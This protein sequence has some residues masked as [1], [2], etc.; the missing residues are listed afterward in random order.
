[1]PINPP[2]VPTD[3]VSVVG[4]S[5]QKATEFCEA[6]NLVNLLIILHMEEAI[7]Q[8]TG[9]MAVLRTCHVVFRDMDGKGSL[10]LTLCEQLL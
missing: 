2:N 6:G 10:W 8:E 3:G 9:S 4:L 1:M 7:R 5:E